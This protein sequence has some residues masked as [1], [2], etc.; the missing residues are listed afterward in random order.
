ME[1]TAEASHPA[2]AGGVG[3]AFSVDMAGEERL[4]LVHE[5]AR[6][7]RGEVEEVAG[8]V[9]EAVALEHEARVEDLV[10][11][12]VG[13]IART[14]SGKIR[15]RATR[16]AYLAGEL[17]VVARVGAADDDERPESG[18]VTAGSAI[19]AGEAA[20]A[21]RLERVDP[22]V[23]LIAQGLDSLAAAELQSAMEARTGVALSMTA[24]LEGASLRALEAEAPGWEIRAVQAVEPDAPGEHP[25]SEGQR[26]L[27]FLDRLAPEAA[28]LHLAGAARVRLGVEALRCAAGLLTR[29]HSAL[30]TTFHERGGE[31]VRRV[32]EWLEPDVREGSLGE[33]FVPFDMERGPLMRL[34]VADGGTALLV[35]VHHLIADYASVAVLLRDLAALYEKRELPPPGP[36]YTA[37]LRRREGALAGP[38]GEELREWWRQRLAGELPVLDLPVDRPR[39]PERSWRGVIRTARLDG[40]LLRDVGRRRGATLYA[41]LLAGL[42]A[43]LHRWTG[44]DEAL[45]AAPTAGRDPGYEGEIGYFVNPVVLRLELRGEPSFEDL[46]TRAGRTAV[47]AFEQGAWPFA[48]LVR[49]LRVPPLQAMFVL[50]PARTPE[51]RA[52]A[53]FALGEAGARA[54]VAGLEMESLA[55]PEARGQ[56]DLT[57]MAAEVG[58]GGILLSLQLDADLFDA[59]TAERLLGHLTNLL[60][61]AA[62]DPGRRVA[63]LEILSGSEREQIAAWSVGPSLPATSPLLLERIAAQAA[64]RPEAVALIHNGERLTYQDLWRRASHLADRLRGLGVGP[65]IRVGICAARTPDMVAAMLAVLEAG[66]AYVPLDPAYPAERLALLL[67]DSGAALVLADALGEERLPSSDLTVIRLGEEA[68]HR[69]VPPVRPAPENLAWLIYTSGS[70]GRPKAVGVTHRSAAAL[71]DWAEDAFPEMDGVLASTS[72]G[73]DLSIFEILL[74]LSRG[75]RVVLAGSALDLPEIPAS[76]GVRLVNTVPSAMAE[77][78]RAGALPASV[79]TVNLAGESLRRE[80]ARGLFAVG[81]RRVVNLYGPSEDTTYSTIADLPPEDDG[82]PPIGRPI[83][84]TTARVLDGELRPVPAGISGELF[85]GGAGLARGYLGRPDLT[86]ERFVP[87]PFPEDGPGARLYRTG[88]R[89]RW[90]PDGQLAFLGRLDYQVKVRGFRIELG[91]VEAAL[92]EIPEVEQVV[93]MAMGEEAERRLVGFIVSGPREGMPFEASPPSLL[94]RPLPP[95]L[96][97]RGGD[98]RDSL[99]ARLPAHMVPSAFVFLDALPLNPNGKV[100]RRAL[101]TMVPERSGGTVPEPPCTPVERRLAAIWGELLDVGEVG[102]RDSFFELGGHSLLLTRLIS[103]VREAFGVELTLGQVFAAPT[104]AAQA[105]LLEGAEAAAEPILPVERTEPIPL[106]SGQERLWFIDQLEGGGAAYNVPAVLRL[107]GPLD[108]AALARALSRIIARHEA[109]RTSFP[110]VDGRPIQVIAPALAIDPPLVDLSAL[111]SPGA[112]AARLPVAEARLPFDLVRG[113]LVRAT[114]LRLGKG[115]HQLLVTLHHAVADGWSLGVFLEELS[116]GYNATEPLPP[117][118]VQYAD[119]TVWQRRRLESGEMDGQIAWWREHLAGAPPRLEIPADR[120]RPSVQ[121]F[122]G[123]QIRRVLPAVAGLGNA[124][125]FM[126]LFAAFAAL[127]QRITGE[128]DLVIGTPVANRARGDLEGLIGFFVNVL[129][130]RAVVDGG[131]SFRALVGALR[132]AILEAYDNQ[133]VPFER[134]VAEL[135]PER[136]PGENPLTQLLFA[137][138]NAPM[139]APRLEGFEVRAEGV[140]NGTAKLDLAVEMTATDAGLAMVLEHSSDLFDPA[141]AERIADRFEILLREVAERPDV[142]VAELDLLGEAERRQISAWERGPAPATAVTGTVVDLFREQARRSPDSPALRFDGTALTYGELERRAAALA[143]HL[144]SRGVGP[145]RVVGLCAHRSPDLAVG[146]LG[147]LAS[148]GVFL[149]LDPAHPA[150]RL[151]YLVRDSG[152]VLALADGTLDLGVPVVTL[153]EALEADGVAPSPPGPGDP[154]Y[155]L[156]T[157]GTTGL[158]KGVLAEHGGLRHTVATAVS[159]FGFEPGERMPS[160]APFSFDIFLFELLAPLLSGGTVSLLPLEPTLDLDLLAG[161]LKHATRFHAVPGVLRAVVDRALANGG[162]FGGLREVYV[163]GDAVPPKLLA[164]ARAAFPSAR[165]RVLYGPTEGTVFCAAHLVNGD[166]PARPV[167]GRPLP[168]NVLTLRDRHGLPVPGGTPG[169]VYIGGPGVTRGYLNRPDLTADRYLPAPGSGRFYRT[170]DL[171]RWRPDG[172]LEFLG[173]ADSQVK[174]RGV[175]IEPGEVEAIL[176]SHPGVRQA[177]VVARRDRGETALAGFYAG[178]VPSEEL[179]TW[180]TGRLPAAMVPAALVPISELP[181]TSRGKVDRRALAAMTLPAAPEAVKTAPRDPMEELLAEIWAGL[182]GVERVGPDED[183]FALGGHSLLATRVVSRVREA[184]GVHLPLRALFEEPTVAKLARRLRQAQAAEAPPLT[185]QPRPAAGAPL[186]FAQQRLWFLWQLAPDSAFYNMPAA[187][188]LRGPINPPLL[189][190]AFGEI[191]RRHE[192]LRTHFPAAGGRPVQAINPSLPVPLPVVDLSGLADEREIER[193]VHEEIRRPFDLARGPVLRTLLLKLGPGNALLVVNLHHIVSDAWSVGVLYREFAEIYGGASPLPGLPV[194]YADFAIW[195]RSWLQGETLDRELSWWRERLAGLP[196]TDLPSDRRRPAVQSFRGATLAAEIPPEI[197]GRLRALSRR[198]GATLFMTLLAGFKALVHRYTGREDVVVGTPVANRERI[199][200]ERLVGFFVN[201]LALRT[202]LV[203]RPGFRGLVERVRETALEA[204]A[205]QSLPFEKIVEALAPDRDAGRQPLFQQMFQLVDVPPPGIEVG[206]LALERLEVDAGTSTFDLALDLHESPDGGIA[207]RAVYST[208][209]FDAATIERLVDHLARLLAGAAEDPELAVAALPM[210]SPDELRQALIEWNDRVDAPPGYPLTHEAFEAR[211]RLTP[212]AVALVCEGERLTYGELNRRA[213]HMAH[214]LI[215]LGAGPEVVVGVLLKRSPRLVVA[216]LAVLKAGAVYLPLDPALPRERLDSMLE[217]AGAAIVI[218]EDWETAAG[219]KG[220]PK[221]HVPGEVLAY[222][223][224]TSG[225]TGRPKGVGVS[226]RALAAHVRAIHE[227]LAL[228]ARDTVLQFASTSF[229]VSL[230]QLLPPLAAGA[231]VV[232]RPEE[233]W[234]LPEL[235]RRLDDE[236]VTVADLPTAYWNQLAHEAARGALP[237]P[238][239]KLRLVIAGGEAL[240]AEAVRRWQRGPFAGVRLLNAYGPTETVMTATVADLTVPGPEGEERVPIGRAVAGRALYVLDPEGGLAPAGVP[241]ELFV[242]GSLLA[243]GYLG[244]PD[245]TAERFVPD[246]FS[247]E[248]GAR[249]YRTGD[250]VRR[251]PDGRL[252]FVGRADRQLKVRGF[253]IEPGEVEAALLRHPAVREAV[254]VARE[255]D[256]RDRRLVAYVTRDAEA[257]LGEVDDWEDEQ[258]EQWRKVYDDDVYGELPDPTFNISGWTSSYTRGPIPAGE[259]REWLDATVDRIFTLL[260]PAGSRMLEIGCG[261]GLVL[262]QVAP[263]CARYVGT[264]FSAV[265]LEHTRSVLEGMER[266]PVELRQGLA[267][268]PAVLGDETFDAVFLS[269]VVQYFPSLDYLLRVLEAA[270]ARVEPGGFVFVGDVRSLPL[271]PAFHASVELHRTHAGTSRE[272]LA[273][274]VEAKIAGDPELVI[275]PAFFAMLRQRLPRI[276]HVEIQLRRGR[277]RNELTRF[278]YDAVLHVGRTEGAEEPAWLDWEAEGLSLSALRGLLEEAPARIGVRRIPNDRVAGDVAALALLRDP[279]GP[280]TAGELRQAAVSGGIDPEDF[281]EAA[282]DLPYEVGVTWSR[283]PGRFDA[284]LRRRD[285]SARAPMPGLCPP[286]DAARL[287]SDPLRRRMARRL[288]PRL[289]AFAAERLPAPMVPAD[290]VI[291]DELPLN[292]RGKVDLRALPAPERTAPGMEEGF[293]PPRTPEE[294][295]VADVWAELLGLDQVGAGDDFFALGGHSLLATQVLSR[296]RQGLGVELELRQLFEEPTVAGLAARVREAAARRGEGEGEP[297]LLPVPRTEP[298]PL[299]FGQRR[300]WFLH[301][302]DPGSAAYN[303]AGAWLLAGLLDIPALAAGWS[304]IARRHEVLRTTY[305]AAGEEPVQVVHPPAPFVPP[306]ADLAGLPS[307]IREAEARRLVA[308]EAARPFDLARGPVL[309]VTLAPAGSARAPGAG[310]NP[311]HR[312]RRLVDRRADPRARQPSMP[313]P[314]PA[315]LRRCPSRRSSTATSQPGS[316]GGSPV[317]RWRRASPGGRTAWPARP[318]CWNCRPTGRVPPCVPQAGGLHPVE[319]PI[320]T[321]AR[322]AGIARAEGATLFAALLAAFQALLG[323]LTGEDDLVVGTPVAGRRQ[324][325]TEELIGFFVNTLALRADLGGRSRLPRAPRPGTQGAALDAFA[326]QDLPFERLVEELRPERSL[327]HA[328]VFQVLFALQN[329]PA[330]PLELPGLTMEPLP[331]EPRALFDLELNVTETDGGLSGALGYALDLF[332]PAT[333]A[334]ISPAIS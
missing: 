98:L 128:E 322:L 96:P 40:A 331:P 192:S 306:V 3:A 328:P 75:G 66:G 129:P 67:E 139:P 54:E 241:G 259:M 112:E 285:G 258:V 88:D 26:A 30:R 185:P 277:H 171:A 297:P 101:A 234:T 175:R 48:R 53:A 149:P 271:L 309:R 237:P 19:L 14:S 92:A 10:L 117:L 300:L 269:S 224:Y 65:E 58:G 298:P 184:F 292:A 156:Y 1:R 201:T 89:V 172:S 95:S 64:R 35:E 59:V 141:T 280:R 334:R 314:S 78:L 213:N 122:R 321:S 212:E 316:A 208:D 229:D 36:G 132:P 182:L 150:E 151:A 41:S 189:A 326:H 71:A 226:H 49:D 51:E 194:Q 32:H 307:G 179:R 33:A 311:P 186:S 34:R 90:R 228:D 176:A 235:L 199:E 221:L 56:S 28:A 25:V 294:R 217:D 244:R 263:R 287:A 227:E 9:R 16:E 146:V 91:E 313:P 87:S 102:V 312:L 120:P 162:G 155:L 85:L 240:R 158:P 308:A 253:R 147:I 69:P 265:A 197:T 252:E 219:R 131:R 284:V 114:L 260:P 211:V 215:S 318:R 153:G 7:W 256:G 125:L 77:L 242:G 299:S 13:S 251:L 107:S 315:A 115:E 216:L 289:K 278:R 180:L 106:S 209:L 61:A 43:V 70:T 136:A 113:P 134:L 52:L 161:E 330:G 195:Q 204:W 262:F 270:V 17:A 160:I 164:D 327:S 261:T 290:V 273:R 108:R 274:R 45:I 272:R 231:R 140:F 57:L 230:E 27:W 116:R 196:P 166:M 239:P 44:Q 303:M 190:R 111:A 177:A 5:V 6:T 198:I 63:E 291:L 110:T 203:G 29:R 11:V 157:S 218:A 123:G 124:T 329:A 281:W 127:L 245:Q 68:E 282:R 165:L 23:P 72:I 152:A 73:F 295:A 275:D 310:D 8:A 159:A 232:L 37:W 255:D 286:D 62:A 207:V 118:P 200:L 154:A 222:V 60:T 305:A 21:L 317:R 183:F 206:G 174:V 325:E 74:P 39:P 266:L 97:G 133:E 332:E 238:P 276:S 15:R 168:G 86:A 84:G 144:A 142:P 293:V 81:V 126:T 130:L 79:E 169:E 163:G 283:E 99:A 249:L 121:S 80:L 205:H 83:A 103:R 76:A 82:E 225:S 119:W 46:V 145:G 191:V 138:Q 214:R 264:D 137:L 47:E 4:V 38:R 12:R 188:R 236:G 109:L 243:R 31:P 202:N 320:A 223:I 148:G 301:R 279:D 55:L 20:R 247:D 220:N 304:E 42:Q 333:A 288:A 143:R 104:I 246:P 24:L 268:D 187:I 167:L 296:V 135:R 319:I 93:V 267:D 302:M 170:G 181:L 50:Q 324:V 105:A 100:D 94:S 323:R 233:V 193:I 254:V 22:D 173:R 178:G 257:G 248:P 2:L 18:A 250:L 210:L